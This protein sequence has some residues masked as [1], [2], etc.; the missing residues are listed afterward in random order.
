M[1]KILFSAILACGASPF[2][3]AQAVIDTVI[4]GNGYANNVW[5]SLE[6]DNQ[7]VQ[8][9]ANWDIALAT[10]VDAGNALTTAALFNFKSGSVY[11]VPGST[12]ATFASVNTSQIGTWTE[13]FNSDTTW[14]LGALNRTTNLGQ[15][16]Y[17]WGNYNMTTH[18]S[19]DANRI[20]VIEY[21]DGSFK[22]F[23]INLSFSGGYTITSANIDNSGQHSQVIPLTP[24]TTKT[25]VYYSIATQTVIDREPAAGTWD[26]TFMQYPYLALGGYP[27]AGVLHSHGAQAAKIHPIASPQTYTNHGAAV[28]SDNISTIGYNWKIAGQ[29]GVVI[30]DSLAYLV[31]TVNGDIW[32]IVFTGFISGGGAGTGEYIFSKELL[33]SLS[34]NESE[35]A[36]FLSV[37][38][39]PAAENVSVS[40]DN[41]AE[42]VIAVY[43]LTG[44]LV[45]T[46]TIS[47]T[48]LQTIAIPAGDLNN[49]LYQVVYTSNGKTATQKLAVQH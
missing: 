34:V 30:E 32:R 12:V 14:T 7:A 20:F 42:A 9:A 31:K 23:Y 21:T 6:N 25:F 28:F 48:G 26:L 15:F 10:V 49:G 33:T 47:E 1:K 16:D 44:S 27:V 24:Y 2:A 18:N 19:I 4:T 35:A 46:T 11:E 40:I 17:G 43:S 3:G 5:Y 22:K 36:P 39:N 37:Y 38:P 13:L 29:N 8:P 45:Y 41:T